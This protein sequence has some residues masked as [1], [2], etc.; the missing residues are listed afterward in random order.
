M[1]ELNEAY[2][3]LSDDALRQRYNRERES[4]MQSSGEFP[5]MA[6]A[7]DSVSSFEVEQY[8]PFAERLQEWGYAEAAIQ[9]ALLARGIRAG[10]AEYLARA[11]TALAVQRTTQGRSAVTD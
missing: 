6:L 1:G 11:V 8:R 4:S 5:E 10:V 9:E 3:V 2:R 7:P